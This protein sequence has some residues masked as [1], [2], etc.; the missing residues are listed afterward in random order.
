M[1]DDSKH[2]VYNNS[3]N[4]A[5]MI[6][7]YLATMNDPLDLGV[8]AR[9]L[10][11]NKSTTYR[12]L[13]AMEE[14]GYVNKD[15]ESG[16]YSL[17]SKVVWLASRFLDSLDIRHLAKPVLKRIM[18]ETGETIH[19]AMLDAL[20]VVYIDKID[21]KQPVQMASRVG[22]RMPAH[23]TGLGKA[24][25][26][27]QPPQ[28][29]HSYVEKIGLKKYTNNT[30]TDAES[31]YACMENDHQRGFS[32]DNFENEDGICCVAVPIYDFKGKP[33]AALSISGWTVSMSPERA[34][35]LAPLAKEAAREISER[36]G[37]SG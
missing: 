23:S 11:V 4:K 8:I 17:G 18:E 27:A 25:L 34:I 24:L 20:E 37:R 10:E 26:M 22:R 30:I 7:E 2:V 12:F 19:L 16:K 1:E 29:W 21:G 3:V 6:L 13:A 14:L 31:F 9:E 33:V 5:F 15:K 28:T 35:S 36:L 32:I